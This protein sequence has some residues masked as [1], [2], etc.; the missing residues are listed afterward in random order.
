MR[1][2]KFSIGGLIGIHLR[3]IVYLG[4]PD[5]FK[6]LFFFFLDKILRAQK[7]ATSKNRLTKQKEANTKQQR[8]QCFK[9]INF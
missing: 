9:R 5:N 8:Q 2:N 4:Y 3:G 7:H 1:T 6:P